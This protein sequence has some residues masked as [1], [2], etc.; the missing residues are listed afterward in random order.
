MHLADA[1]RPRNRYEQ[2]RSDLMTSN[3]LPKL[4]ILIGLG[5]L[6]STPYFVMRSLSKVGP[7]H[8]FA[9]E[10]NVA[11]DDQLPLPY[12]FPQSSPTP[13][14]EKKQ[15][16]FEWDWPRELSTED[17][18]TVRFS[19][20]TV[21]ESDWPHLDASPEEGPGNERP[22]FRL[23]QKPLASAFGS[24]YTVTATASLDAPSFKITPEGDVA[25]VLDE[26]NAEWR[27]II[28]P[29]GEGSKLMNVRVT[30]E[31]VGS[32]K[33]HPTKKRE[34][35][36]SLKTEVGK[37]LVKVGTFEVIPWVTGISGASLVGIGGFVIGKRKFGK[38]DKDEEES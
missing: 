21:A 25:K 11:S 10:R 28:T 26:G 7:S 5:L 14:T 24:G 33:R 8:A 3:T 15:T 13:L 4:S 1:T 34:W 18:G 23:P 30:V 12:Q 16:A 9:I 17:E 32:D 2:M 37:P 36:K 27:W 38:K 31:W 19:A 20:I 6:L 29:L 35:R 22:E